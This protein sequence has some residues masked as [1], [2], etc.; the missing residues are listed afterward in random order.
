M[1]LRREYDAMPKPSQ[2]FSEDIVII[3]LIL[4]NISPAP[5]RT[6]AGTCW[7]LHG[8]IRDHLLF[9]SCPP[10]TRVSKKGRFF[11]ICQRI[12]PDRSIA[13]FLKDPILPHSRLK[14]KKKKVNTGA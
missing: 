8:N 6:T 14:A 12:I 13:F 11:K 5:L 7:F 3:Y 2:C 4:R 10:K 1:L 9:F